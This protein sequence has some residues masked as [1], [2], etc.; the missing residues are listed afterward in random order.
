MYIKAG[1]TERI[2][3]KNSD[4]DYSIH[5]LDCH[6]YFKKYFAFDLSASA[7]N[8]HVSCVAVYPVLVYGKMEGYARKLL[9]FFNMKSNLRVL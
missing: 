8:T 3:R 7:G 9:Q 1:S 6:I 2:L 4:N 5:F